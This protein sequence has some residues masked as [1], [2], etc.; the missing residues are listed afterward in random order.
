MKQISVQK[1]KCL[2]S[3]FCMSDRLNL[4]QGAQHIDIMPKSCQQKDASIFESLTN[5]IQNIRLGAELKKQ[6]TLA[7]LLYMRPISERCNTFTFVLKKT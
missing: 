2:A 1:K 6:V 4:G 3:C 7:V 5:A